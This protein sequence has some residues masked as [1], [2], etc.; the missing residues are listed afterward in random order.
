MKY[1]SLLHRLLLSWLRMRIMPRNFAPFRGKQNICY[2]LSKRSF[3]DLLVLEQVCRK[4]NIAPPRVKPKF[5]PQTTGQASYFYLQ[6][7]NKKAHTATIMREM[8]EALQQKPQ[9]EINIVPVSVFWGRNPGRMERSFWRVFFS[10]AEN[11]HPIKRFFIIL[12]K[13]RDI[14]VN[15]G[16]PI[17][18]Q[19]FVQQDSSSD[20]LQRKLNRVLRVHFRTQKNSV[21]G[22][23]LYNRQHLI[24]SLL[25]SANVAATINSE[26]KRSGKAITELNKKARKYLEAICADMSPRFILLFYIVLTWVFKKIFA[27]LE[28]KTPPQL[29]DAAR[30]DE[31]I[32]LPSHRSHMDYLLL[33]YVL[34]KEGLMTPHI[35]S[36][37]NLNIMLIGT[38]LRKGGAFFLKRKFRGN[39]LYTTLFSEYIHHLVS[40]GYPLCFFLEGGRSR[41]GYLREPKT[42]M[43]AMI[44]NSYQRDSFRKI[45]LVPVYIGYDR[46]IEA[47][48]LLNEVGGQK[49]ADESLWEIIKARK[50]LKSSFGKVYVRFGEPQP[51]DN[52][53]TDVDK[54]FNEKVNSL[55][56]VVM[57]KIVNNTVL[58]PHSII[59]TILLAKKHRSIAIREFTTVFKAIRHLALRLEWHT[60]A[61]FEH[62]SHD[63]LL[64]TV[65]KMKQIDRFLCKTGDDI[66]YLKNKHDPAMV[67]L[68]NNCVPIFL[69]PSLI[70]HFAKNA[71][72]QQINKQDIT[73]KVSRYHRLMAQEFFL[74]HDQHTDTVINQ[75]LTEMLAIGLL[76][77]DQKPKSNKKRTLLTTLSNITFD[78]TSRYELLFQMLADLDTDTPHSF[79]DL[80]NS[81]SLLLNRT[82]LLQ[83]GM[84]SEF[85]RERL[86]AI[87]L[88]SLK[89]LGVLIDSGDGLVNIQP[90][91]LL[92]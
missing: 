31:L 37:D 91:S 27:G 73:V 24:D 2:V 19:K 12:V 81:F 63:K 25:K 55:A 35:G 5:L 16:N 17:S 72:D 9:Q 48:S 78:I 90:E 51:L 89:R 70:A 64:Q 46:V 56:Q 52:F 69:I 87:Q 76:T 82:A 65:S 47:N 28:V 3:S 66:L 30:T 38:L 26:A 13:G 60:T 40:K 85:N 86:A 36:G 43:L 29:A 68:A 11:V 92:R 34:Y 1:L 77:F 22:P 8:I 45:S 6:V 49:I 84:I 10:D 79:H 58:T 83:G 62:L 50:I 4:R 7:R 61:N 57:K 21:L 54:P 41:T 32:Y 39:R 75:T 23:V 18:L 44:V 88:G 59:A 14:L 53:M 15:F 74:T 71:N 33:S 42:G 20:F 67:Y 80:C